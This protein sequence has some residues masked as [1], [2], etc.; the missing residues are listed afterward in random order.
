MKIKK[1]YENSSSKISVEELLIYQDAQ[2][3]I[4]K[5]QQLLPKFIEKYVEFCREKINPNI[6]TLIIDDFHVGNNKVIIEVC[7]A[8][9]ERIWDTL[10]P[11]IEEFVDFC[12]NIK[13]YM[14]SKKYN[15]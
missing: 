4:D 1:I 11:S 5:Y 3:I 8:D 12:N 14:T 7:D 6:E 10:E 9:Y 13:A 15:L 2:K